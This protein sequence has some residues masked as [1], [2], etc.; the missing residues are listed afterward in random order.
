MKKLQLFHPVCLT[1]FL[2]FQVQRDP[3]T[4]HFRIDLAQ[5][6]FSN[7]PTWSV[8]HE[9]RTFRFKRIIG[10]RGAFMDASYLSTGIIFPWNKNP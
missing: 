9:F 8:R 3:G 10:N 4:F 2:E 1:D 5:P 7:T 6:A